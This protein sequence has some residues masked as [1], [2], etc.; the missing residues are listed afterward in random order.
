[1]FGLWVVLALEVFDVFTE[2]EKKKIR[3]LGLL[4]IVV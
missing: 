2:R 1:M 3:L 4:F